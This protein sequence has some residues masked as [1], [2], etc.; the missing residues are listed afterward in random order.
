MKGSIFYRFYDFL[1]SPPGQVETNAKIFKNQK[2]ILRLDP[3]TG[4]GHHDHVKTAGQDSKFGIPVSLLPK[5]KDH[6]Q[7]NNIEVIG[8]H[9]HSGSGISDHQHWKELAM[10]LLSHLELFPQVKIIN[11]GGGLVVPYHSQEKDA[12]LSQ[13]TGGQ[14]TLDHFG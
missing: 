10:F 12:Q 2:I 14:K 1:S 4:R 6:C 8:L 13:F 7:E 5:I 9:S 3:G 11:L